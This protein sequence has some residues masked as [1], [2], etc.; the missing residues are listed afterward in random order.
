MKKFAL[1]FIIMLFLILGSC[2]YATEVELE[3][4]NI[5]SMSI[6]EFMI[7]N[8]SKQAKVDIIRKNNVEMEK[9]KAEL[10]DKIV[11]AAEKINDLKFEISQDNVVITD[12]SLEELKELLEFLQDSRDTLEEDVERTLE[13]IEKILDLIVT[14]G[15]HLEQYDK[16][17]EK[18]NEVIVKMKNVMET[19]EMI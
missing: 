10:K 17:I 8:K 3:E 5:P 18:Q 1:C 2:A 19:V 6:E 4:G 15:M 14:R 13:E 11:I 9:L 7:M 12:E 16:L